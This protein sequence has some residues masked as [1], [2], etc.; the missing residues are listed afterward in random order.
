MQQI[1]GNETLTG[2][3]TYI[4]EE[5]PVDKPHLLLISGIRKISSELLIIHSGLV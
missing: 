4:E 1:D 2:L 5:L 3:I